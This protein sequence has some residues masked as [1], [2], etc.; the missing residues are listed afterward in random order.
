MVDVAFVEL[1]MFSVQSAL[2][3][4]QIW[5]HGETPHHRMRDRD[6]CYND[7]DDHDVDLC[8]VLNFCR[9]KEG[10]G[11][12]RKGEFRVD[13]MRFGMVWVAWLFRPDTLSS[14]H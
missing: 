1:M 10:D 9:M 2:V 14:L 12:W 4:V 6:A 8:W 5:N 11:Q 3:S 13:G 7:H